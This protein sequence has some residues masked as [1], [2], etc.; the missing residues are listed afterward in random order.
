MNSVQLRL[1]LRRILLAAWALFAVS[2]VLPSVD[3]D[4]GA[5]EQPGP[6]PVTGWYAALVGFW[7]GYFAPANS[8]AAFGP[9]IFELIRPAGRNPHRVWLKYTLATVMLV[10]AVGALCMI[11]YDAFDSVHSGFW[12]WVGSLSLMAGVFFFC[13][14]VNNDADLN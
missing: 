10:S 1:P 12:C 3:Y 8:I 14:E 7:I 2:L 11:S 6:Q 9:L 13:P 5:W 4:M